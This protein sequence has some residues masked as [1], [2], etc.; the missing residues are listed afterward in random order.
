MGSIDRYEL[1]TGHCGTPSLLLILTAG[2]SSGWGGGVGGGGLR[3]RKEKKVGPAINFFSRL[4]VGKD[5]HL[6]N[7]L[8]IRILI[9]EP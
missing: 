6:F 5:K 4:L 2:K 8:C 3:R 7:Y 9:D 1:Q